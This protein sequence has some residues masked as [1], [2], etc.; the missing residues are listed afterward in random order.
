MFCPHNFSD[1]I[2]SS[3]AIAKS[4]RSAF[5]IAFDES[6]NCFKC[7]FET[8]MATRVEEQHTRNYNRLE[9]WPDRY[10]LP[11][12]RY[13]DIN[14]ILEAGWKVPSIVS[15]FPGNG[16][17]GDHEFHGIW[18]YIP[19]LFHLDVS[20]ISLIDSIRPMDLDSGNLSHRAMR[21]RKC[22]LPNVR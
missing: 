20:R 15:W 22:R 10:R 1:R 13:E 9:Q 17:S 11:P 18:L 5:L 7:N 2:Q 8:G 19:V 16:F 4:P 21:E 3:L 12:E 14:P 6:E